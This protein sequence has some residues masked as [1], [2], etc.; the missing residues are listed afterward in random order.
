LKII[1]YWFTGELLQCC[2][3]SHSRTLLFHFCT[4]CVRTFVYMCS[5]V[6]PVVL[7]SATRGGSFLPRVIYI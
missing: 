7:S 3:K 2:L 1:S 6:L 5:Q 4:L